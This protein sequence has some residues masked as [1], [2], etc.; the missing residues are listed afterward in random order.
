MAASSTFEA[1][2][3]LSLSFAQSRVVILHQHLGVVRHAAH[4][5][6]IEPHPSPLR[7]AKLSRTQLPAQSKIRGRIKQ[8]LNE[9][10]IHWIKERNHVVHIAPRHASPCTIQQVN[11]SQRVRGNQQPDQ[12]LRKHSSASS[13]TSPNTVPTW[14]DVALT[15]RGKSPADQDSESLALLAR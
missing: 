7:L 12:N 15:L 9:R 4:H 11:V 10:Y 5:L 6:Q 14:P 3:E 2:S 1:V 8:R 13:V